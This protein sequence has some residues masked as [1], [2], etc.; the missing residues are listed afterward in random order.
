[1]ID[2]LPH[3]RFTAVV[4]STVQHIEAQMDKTSHGTEYEVGADVGSLS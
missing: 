3:R 2:T 1:M 4:A